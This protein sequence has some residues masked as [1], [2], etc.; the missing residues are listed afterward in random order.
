MVPA[1]VTRGSQRCS[2]ETRRSVINSRRPR[3][4]RRPEQS[5]YRRG[6]REAPSPSSARSL[7]PVALQGQPAE[8]SHLEGGRATVL[9]GAEEV[10]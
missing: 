6:R 5:N 8:P 2:W 9:D 4:Q 3:R 7:L 10:R 1:V